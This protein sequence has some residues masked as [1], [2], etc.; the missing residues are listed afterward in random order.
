MSSSFQ[1]LA[2]T[3][4]SSFTNIRSASDQSQQ[5][6]RADDQAEDGNV[7]EAI[8]DAQID[9]YRPQDVRSLLLPPLI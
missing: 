1:P 8:T 5:L 3:S 9:L 7:E 4:S 2:S 6:S